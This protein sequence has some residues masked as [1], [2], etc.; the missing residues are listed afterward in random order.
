MASRIDQALNTLRTT[1]QI[2]G[3]VVDEAV[4]VI[5]PEQAA[6]RRFNRKTFNASS[7][8]F[9]GADKTR[10]RK[11]ITKNPG[12]NQLM[13]GA[14][15]SLQS[16]VR[17]LERNHD[18]SRGVINTLVKNVV[19]PKGIQVE[20]QP[21]DKNGDYHEEFAMALMNLHRDWCRSPEVTGQ[22]NWAQCQHI[23]ARSLFRDGEAFSQNVMGRVRGLDHG[24]EVPFSIELFEA[25]Y[26]PL[27]LNE[28]SKRIL[29]GIGL[30]EWNRPTHYY[31]HKNHPN[32]INAAGEVGGAMATVSEM[33]KVDAR[34]ILHIKLVDRIGQLRGN[35]VLSSVISRMSDLKEFE[36]AERVAAKIGAKLSVVMTRD[37]E[38]AG[39]GFYNSLMQPDENGESQFQRNEMTLSDGMVFYG[40]LP[41]EDIQMIDNKRPNDNTGAFRS[42]QV[43]MV[44]AGADVSHSTISRDYS[45]TYAAQRQELVETWPS[46]QLLT[47]HFTAGFVAPVWRAFVQMAVTAGLVEVP[48]NLDMSSIDD[49]MYIGPPMPWIDILKEAKASNELL[50]TQKSLTETLRERGSNSV[51]FFRN[52]KRDQKLAEKHGISFESGPVYKGDPAENG[53]GETV[54]KNNE[55]EGGQSAAA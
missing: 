46:Y 41:G 52:V 47:T 39:G 15:A 24:T 23:A 18:L 31:L 53:G 32:D 7:T 8:G 54:D 38:A 19:G 26:C 51:E 17:H 49:A 20:P 36:D 43:K 21:V 14:G 42:D 16:Q 2:A 35:S 6:K 22:M 1:A 50:G 9:E 44:A 34:N 25:D 55:K 33:R 27:E 48:D 12:G 45:G 3:A 11:T 4:A 13:A 29:Q 5:N 37:P 30:N 40:L 28:P 10:F